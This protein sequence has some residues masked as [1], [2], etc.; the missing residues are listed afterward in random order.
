VGVIEYLFIALFFGMAVCVPIACGI[1]F[2]K[3][4]I[5]SKIL[6]TPILLFFIA[7][8]GYGAW[9][10]GLQLYHG[11]TEESLLLENIDKAKAVNTSGEVALKEITPFEWEAMCQLGI[12]D[13]YSYGYP[14]DEKQIE[15]YKAMGSEGFEYYNDSERSHLYLFKT[16]EGI[17][18]FEGAF[19]DIGELYN[20][21]PNQNKLCFF[22][23]TA[24]IKIK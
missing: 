5:A 19:D 17:K 21:E 1:W 13:D 18:S 20:T 23:S 4:G 3:G 8:Y 9:S 14:P 10:F 15:F 22:P 12:Y 16:V 11:H 6:M 7:L 24:H 2:Y